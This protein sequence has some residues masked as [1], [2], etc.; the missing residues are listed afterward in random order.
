[1][2]NPTE[3][4]SA[5][6]LQNI[7]DRFA[8]LPPGSVVE[9]HYWDVRDHGL[10]LVEEILRLRGVVMSNPTEAPRRVQQ[11]RAKGLRQPD[12]TTDQWVT[13]PDGEEFRVGECQGHDACP[14]ETHEHGCFADI[15]NC[16]HPEEHAVEGSP[17]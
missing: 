13:A 1:M 4:L 8:A 15:G 6:V 10:A 3:G 11:K 2:S 17:S 16:D 7:A 9:G 5:T 12:N 14:V